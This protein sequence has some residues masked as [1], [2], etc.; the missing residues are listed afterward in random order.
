MGWD[1]RPQ[2]CGIA[3]EFE[4]NSVLTGGGLWRWVPLNPEQT[5]EALGCVR[6]RAPGAKTLPR[7]GWDDAH[8]TQV[9]TGRRPQRGAAGDFPGASFQPGDQKGW[10]KS[11]VTQEVNMNKSAHKNNFSGTMIPSPGNAE[12]FLRVP[13]SPC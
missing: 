6:G 11:P 5:L 9:T 13:D 2:P 3:W 12:S 8:E 7:A 4:R 1:P 10:W